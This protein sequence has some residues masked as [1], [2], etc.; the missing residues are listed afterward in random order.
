[1]DLWNDSPLA[2]ELIADGEVSISDALTLETVSLEEAGLEETEESTFGLD[3]DAAHGVM[4]L[5]AWWSDG[6]DAR[7][8]LT[9]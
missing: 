2:W 5:V 8:W 9:Q 4:A 7:D 3:N 6:E 1:M